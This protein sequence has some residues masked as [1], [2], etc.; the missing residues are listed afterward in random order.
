VR[1]AIKQ[2]EACRQDGWQTPVELL[3]KKIVGSWQSVSTT[4]AK[5]PAGPASA[6]ATHTAS[7]ASPPPPSGV[8]FLLPE[9]PP[10]TRLAPRRHAAHSKAET[11]FIVRSEKGARIQ[12]IAPWLVKQRRAL[13]PRSRKRF[14]AANISA[15]MSPKDFQPVEALL[16]PMLARLAREGGAVALGPIWAQVAGPQIA[17]QVRPVA[18]EGGALVLE[19]ATARWQAEVSAL[20]ADLLQ[21]LNAALGRERVERLLVRLASAHPDKAEP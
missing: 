7:P 13:T 1:R 18:F 14:A 15:L 8:G 2:S 19:A 3:Q 4:Q 5:H 17:R 11:D 10:V 12:G 6:P 9:Q 20:A 21:K 16:T